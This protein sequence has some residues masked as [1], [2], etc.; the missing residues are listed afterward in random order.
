MTTAAIYATQEV[1]RSRSFN[2]GAVTRRYTYGLQRISESQAISG[3]WTTSYYG[4]DGFGT[5]RQLTN[6][7]GAVT[8]TYEYDAF[9]NSFTKSGT[10]PNNYLYRGEQFDSDL[11]L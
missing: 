3:K 10:T 4:Y 8:D 5:V 1:S 6:S 11:D 7:A 9:G 2:R